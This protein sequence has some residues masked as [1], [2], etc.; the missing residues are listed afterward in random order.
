MREAPAASS[1]VTRRESAS[2]IAADAVEQGGR[3]PLADVLIVAP[4][5]YSVMIVEVAPYLTRTSSNGAL[6]AV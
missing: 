4:I 1:S 3:E 2:G 6:P 5:M